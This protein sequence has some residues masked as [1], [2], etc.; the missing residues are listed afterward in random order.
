MKAMDSQIAHSNVSPG[1]LLEQFENEFWAA[2]TACAADPEVVGFKSVACYR[3]GLDVA[4]VPEK[5]SVLERSVMTLTLVYAA[6]RNL[7]LADKALNDYV[8]NKTM[9]IS[10]ECGKPGTAPFFS[11]M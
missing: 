1:P 9:R 6:R 5:I 8:V 4:P 2:L 7:R 10:A 3:T 11:V